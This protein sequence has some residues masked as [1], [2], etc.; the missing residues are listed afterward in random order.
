MPSLEKFENKIEHEIKRDLA[1]NS[2]NKPHSVLGKAVCLSVHP[3]KLILF[4]FIEWFNRHFR[5]KFKFA[6]TVF[7]ITLLVIG[8]VLTL[9]TLAIMAYF[10]PQK[11][12]TDQISFNATVAPHE[13]V[14]GAPSTLVIQYHN[15]TK[16]ALRNAKLDLNFPDHFL[17]QSISVN[18]QNVNDKNIDLG[19]VPIGGSGTI[20]V[21]GVMF[22]DV[23][24][25]QTFQSSMTFV[26]GTKGDI[27]EQKNSSYTFSPAHSTLALSLTLPP[28]V[29][30]GQP[31]SGFI[32]YKNTGEI[33]F[34]E[35]SVS[36]EW[37]KG[38]TVKNTSVPQVNGL[39]SLPKI[40]A[41]ASGQM[42]F[43]GFLGTVPDHINFIFHPSFT[44]G[45]DRYQQETLTQSIPI[46]PA[47]LSLVPHLDTVV[48]KPGTDAT[49]TIHYKNIGTEILNNVDIGIASDCPFVK[50]GGKTVSSNENTKLSTV[51]PND[52]GDITVVI[53]ILASVP[54]SSV[55]SYVNIQIQTHAIAHYRLASD[56]TKEQLTT[57]TDDTFT[58]LTTPL[59]LESFARYVTPSGDQI[60]RGPL[61]PR[62]GQKTSYW[63]F[64]NIDGTTN[65]LN[66]VSISGTL[67]ANV[68]YSGIDTSSE[69]GGVT[70][71][72]A[73]NQISWNVSPVPPTFDPTSRLFSVAFEVILTP[74]ADQV[75][76]TPIL[77]QNINLTATD[78]FTSQ[79]VSTSA[80]NITTNIPTDKMAKGKGIVR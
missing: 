27:P 70:Y 49:F 62:V 21:Q 35:I 32:T 40:K 46:L 41:G 68:E 80:A 63:I 54:A 55:T 39:Y 76:K 13:I 47:Q 38:F 22:G 15:A 33:D 43:T 42:S 12:F 58:K 2:V 26:H 78:S 5:G 9:L 52:E 31:I 56:A 59:R 53:P 14:T 20:H 75:G 28:R 77:L 34:P 45:P 48:L 72:A 4:P 29:I 51:K 6:K 23:G 18:D 1:C 50:N 79:F 36:P 44:F 30:A 64:W 25:K 60:G 10:F 11:N 67:P 61:P 37:P 71:N 24:G 17:L 74:T 16:E 3:G 57:T 7:A 19:T 73:T 69:D 66:R 8:S 65:E